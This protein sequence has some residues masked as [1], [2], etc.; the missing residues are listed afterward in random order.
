MYKYFDQVPEQGVL[1]VLLHQGV[2]QG[3]RTRPEIGGARQEGPPQGSHARRCQVLQQ[4][5]RRPQ[6]VGNVRFGKHAS[7][8]TI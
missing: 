2:R 6:E 3:P 1:A 7:P 4:A 5:G 8:L